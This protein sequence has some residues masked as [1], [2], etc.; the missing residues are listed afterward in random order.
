MKK[1]LANEQ[2][3]LIII[4]VFLPVIC[5]SESF[6]TSSSWAK[7]MISPNNIGSVPFGSFRVRIYEH[8]ENQK[9]TTTPNRK[10][11]F[12][13]PIA[14]LDQNSV[15]N[16]FNDITNQTEIQF[17]IELWNE[18]VE[19]EVTN[20]LGKIVGEKIEPYQIQVIPF[21]NVILTSPSETS[22]FYFLPTTWSSF[23]LQKSL[24]FTVACFGQKDCKKLTKQMC[25]SPQQ[26]QSLQ[27]RFSLSSQPSKPKEAEIAVSGPMTKRL[28]MRF[29][30][31]KYILE[32]KMNINF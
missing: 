14:L 20:Y 30:Q 17:R 3:L 31:K 23:N 4:K 21:E 28:L 29:T 26:L 16:A 10:R 11:Y 22:L 2:I 9:E 32:K 6:G 27:L 25:T 5:A 8:L 7:L 15:T 24:W 13:A 1:S 19:S 18:Q 12:Y